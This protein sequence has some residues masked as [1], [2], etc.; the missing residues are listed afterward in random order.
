MEQEI[1]NALEPQRRLPA[2]P[3]VNAA[4]LNPFPGPRP[5]GAGERDR[6][7]GREEAAVR[8]E[9]HLLSYPCTTLFGPSGSGKSSLMQAAVLPKL[10]EAHDYRTVWVDFWP[11]EEAPLDQFLE[12][13]F[14]TLEIGAPPVG[15]GPR[16][17]VNLAMDRAEQRSD[18]PI[19]I[20]LDQLERLLFTGRP[21]HQLDALLQAADEL[22]QRPTHDL[23]VVLALRE[24]YLGRLRD[25]SRSYKRL[26]QHSF[27]LGPLTVRELGGAVCKAA[28]RGV[29]AQTWP[30]RDV[31]ALMLDVRAPGQPASEDAEVQAA[32]AQ[33]VCRA[34]WDAGG[35]GR[36]RAE[37]I[38]KR[39]LD[40][41]LNELDA[42]ARDAWN[43]L[44][45]ELIDEDGHRKLLTEERAR[46]VLPAG[47]AKEV[48]DKLLKEAVLL[49]REH[50]GSRYFELGHDWLAK[51]VFDQRKER[52]QEEKRQAKEQEDKR[53]RE[54][55]DAERDARLAQEKKRRWIVG[56]AVAVSVAAVLLGLGIWALVERTEAKKATATARKA[57]MMSGIRELLAHDQTA[58]AANLL[59]A[60]SHPEREPAW[61]NLAIET[62]W[63]EVPLLTFRGHRNRVS[64]VAVSPDG[65]R[66]LTASEDGTA[67][68][69]N[70]DGLGKSMVLKHERDVTSAGWS[71]DGK[72]VVTSSWDKTV[73]IWEAAGGKEIARHRFDV[74]VLYAT[75]NP[76]PAG[77]HVLVLIDGIDGNTPQLWDGKDGLKPL[78]G[79]SQR[80]HFARFSP[81]GDRIVTASA[82]GTAR[83]WLVRDLTNSI[84]LRHEGPVNTARF[85]LDGELVV[86]T[87]GWTIRVFRADGSDLMETLS[88][89]PRDCKF[90]PNGDRLVSIGGNGGT[91]WTRGQ[92]SW[93][94][95]EWTKTEVR[96]SGHTGAVS[97]VHWTRDG[98]QLVTTS[99]D[100]TARL[101][102]A[103]DGR[104]IAV[105]RG[106]AGMLYSADIAAD[107]TR[108]VTGSLDTTVRVWN[109]RGW[110]RPIALR[111]HSKQAFWVAVSP[112]GEKV[113]GAS[114]D[115]V[116]IW[117]LNGIGEPVVLKE[118]SF[119]SAR[120]SPDGTKIVTAS[121]DG[122]ARIWNA[123]GRGDPTKLP[124]AEFRLTDTA[125][126]P[127]GERI[128]AASHG[129]IATVW[130][131][132][133]AAKL[134]DLTGHSES[135]TSAVWSPDGRYLLTASRDRTARI[136]NG[137]DGVLVR[138]LKGHAGGVVAA[139]WCQ[140][141]KRIVTGSHDG[142]VRVWSAEGALEP[143]VLRGHES[144]VAAAFS[145]DCQRVAS[146]SWDGTARI[147]NADGRGEPIV[148]RVLSDARDRLNY[149]LAVAWSH[150]GSR[151][152]TGSYD[153]V[154]RVW[155][156]SDLRVETLKS[157][158][159][160][161]TLDCLPP[162]LRERHLD[163]TREQAR[164][165]YETCERGL[166]REPEMVEDSF[167]R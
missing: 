17:A 25:R 113:L 136:W 99:E 100:T 120:W 42:L 90:S 75:F 8:F 107:D 27:R 36:Y 129:K 68:I 159:A 124:P 118:Q 32:F 154:V 44:E 7:F 54:I 24:D 6:F 3:A 122:V 83:V 82:D 22:A 87:S 152:I 133:G 30:D 96:L 73:R 77:N 35:L 128:V 111:G 146:A 43:L 106:H 15:L 131:I 59:S 142:T 157:A 112:N 114:D 98:E 26:L 51:K 63:S 55:H 148:I 21:A 16:E 69:W 38:L 80:V 74:S 123:D 160:T 165:A 143:I 135:V 161:A 94:D 31:Q 12:N 167:K 70:V 132:Q 95:K 41:T 2:K 156:V 166:G 110:H 13:L 86:T 89:G 64:H 49:D 127:D 18:Q 104:P 50:E 11:I 71:P 105:F 10:R 47:A 67:R 145:P 72:H 116:R 57:H 97:S 93:S 79:H 119:T 155:D 150:D 101:W 53:A 76:D 117:N 78:K 23:H 139:E 9:R 5:Y 20:Y 149:V 141:S 164:A 40:K 102:S 85:S 144:A 4:P 121:D 163:E 162:D 52:E 1:S 37:E 140:D 19:L 125:W 56:F 62:L 39:H 92:K 153:G 147:W 48:L 84:V 65:K 60:V 14:S 81:K 28:A 61:I 58:S 33:I 45:I 108:I 46:S 34:T 134:F 91:V 126:S 109:I 29:P 158:L 88:A 151:L 137:N 115:A 103:R 66:V 130:R 138:E